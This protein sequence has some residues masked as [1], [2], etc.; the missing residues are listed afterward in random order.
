MDHPIYP[1]LYGPCLLS[2]FF[3][4]RLLLIECFAEEK[5]GYS[6]Q[7]FK[8]C[9][10]SPNNIF[11]T[12][13]LIGVSFGGEVIVGS[14]I[15]S[16]NIPQPGLPSP[17]PGLPGF[18]YLFLFNFLLQPHLVILYLYVQWILLHLRCECS[19]EHL[20]ARS[21]SPLLFGFLEGPC[22]HYFAGSNCATY[23]E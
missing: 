19:D 16:I 15:T 20:P 10:C 7:F 23:D 21:I 9:H 12:M 22:P 17:D 14:L 6:V 3:I 4:Y 1:I 8:S 18:L 5:F 13:N 11:K 2:F